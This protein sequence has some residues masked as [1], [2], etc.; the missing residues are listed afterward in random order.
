MGLVP[1][2]NEPYLDWTDESNQKAMRAALVEVEALGKSHPVIL[3]S[4][5]EA[6]LLL[7]AAGQRDPCRQPGRMGVFQRIGDE[8][9]GD[10]TNRQGRLR[11]QLTVRWAVK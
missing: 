4:D 10:Q 3:I 6:P 7:T 8:F 9:C 11:R 2:K 5:H 1:Y